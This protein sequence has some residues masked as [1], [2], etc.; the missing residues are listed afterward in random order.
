VDAIPQQAAL[1]VRQVSGNSLSPA[2]AP[3]HLTE[4]VDFANGLLA[5]FTDRL[6]RGALE[7]TTTVLSL[8]TNKLVRRGAG[9]LRRKGLFQ[10]VV[11]LLLLNEGFG[12]YRAYLAGGALGYW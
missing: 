5:M 9:W 3:F 1:A 11:P 7:A 12:A 10:Y 6:T 4:H 2:S 8:G